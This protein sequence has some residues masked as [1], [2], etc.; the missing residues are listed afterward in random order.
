MTPL[1][2]HHALV[3]GANRGIGAAVA[4]HLARAGA[5]VSLLVRS[6]ASAAPLAAELEKMGARAAVVEADV[7]DAA[8]LGRAIDQAI[9]ALGPVDVL[10]NN[11]GTAESAPFLKS[12]DARFQRMLAVHLLAPVHAIQA[13]L[14]AMLARGRGRVVNVASIAG[15][16]GGAYIAAYTAAKHA[17]VGLTRALA[18]ELAGKGVTVNAVC[19]GYTDTELVQHAVRRIVDKTGRSADDAVAALLKDAGQHRLIGVDEVAAAVLAFARPDC[20][21][22]GEARRV[23]GEDR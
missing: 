3:T 2:G 9:A 19:P 11:A 10:V 15:L 8:A 7:T 4:R 6:R 5:N 23:M 16:E 1:S 22:S 18:C 21:V 13:V 17:Q 14:P 20:T 12:D